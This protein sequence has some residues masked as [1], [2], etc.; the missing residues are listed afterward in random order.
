[1]NAS[2]RSRDSDLKVLVGGPCV[3]I[4]NVARPALAAF[5]VG[6]AVLGSPA[7]LLQFQDPQ[8]CA[9]DVDPASEAEDV[10]A[11]APVLQYESLSPD[12]Q[13]AFESARTARGSDVVTGEA[14]PGSFEY[15]VDRSQYVIVQDDSR[16]VLT[17]YQNDL[18]PEVWI[19]AGV[20]ADL[21]VTL[22][23]VGILTRRNP[24]ARFPVGL[25]AVGATALLAVTAAVVLDQQL[26]FALGWT[27]VVTAG[28]FVGAGA[29]LPTRTAGVL[30]A[31]LA[32]LPLVAALPVVS[33]SAVFVAPAVL[34]LVLVGLGVGARRLAAVVSGQT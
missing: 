25:A 4:V 34:P 31:A 9:N 29:T 16:Y 5:V 6:L 24:D 19:A 11:S 13:R 32:V 17:T 21:G 14:C 2:E 18:L 10:P 8:E 1:V 12:A 15:G 30:G 3:G 26:W 27:G 28:A 22:V 7:V 33:A 20:L 23:G